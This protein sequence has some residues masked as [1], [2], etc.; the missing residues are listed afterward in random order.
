MQLQEDLQ[1]ADARLQPFNSRAGFLAAGLTASCTL[2]FVVMIVVV[3]F[4]LTSRP[5]AIA[6]SVDFRIFWA[7]GKLAVAGEPLAVHDLAR[8]GAAHGTQTQQYMPWL[9]PP[10]YLMLV[11]P[12][13]TLSFAM[14]FLVWTVLAMG[15]ILW[16]VRPFA[17]GVKP[18]WALVALAPAFYPTLMLGQ[19][20]LFWMAGLMAALA[21]LARERWVLAGVFIGLLT[22]K[23]QLG[24]MI[25][26]ALLA[27]G[28]WR[29]IL[30]AAATAVILAGLPT[31]YYGLDY[32]P[33]LLVNV[34]EQGASIALSVPNI[35]LMISPI[36]ALT[37]YG[38]DPGL[39]WIVHW[40]IA[41]G[42]LIAVFLLWRSKRAVFDTKAAGLLCA[43]LLSAPYLWY[44]EGV[45]LAAIALFLV[46]GE[47]LDLRPLHL[48]VLVPL[49]V[50]GGLQ[51]I[52]T[53]LQIIDQRWLGAAY[54]SPLLLLCL[55]LCLRQTL[56]ARQTGGMPPDSTRA[57]P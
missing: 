2:V 32:W 31:L 36:F 3:A 9:Y 55:G 49:W 18:V 11:T 21:A 46:R 1:A 6:M 51:A 35:K 53:F 45:L 37:F 28:A 41:A 48:L 39:G 15:L 47:V 50:G 44:Y 5:D 10:G 34:H 16:A 42:A 4:V 22:L 12:L 43:I 7:A 14:A 52:N 57:L 13:G 54:I 17:A 20:S 56:P 40:T 26:V 8:L 27:I 29:T 24:V 33:L 25:P 30:T 38:V 23:P 19:N